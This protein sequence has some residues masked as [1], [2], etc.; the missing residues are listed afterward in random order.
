M[1]KK[2]Y[3][4]KSKIKTN[5]S[6]RQKSHTDFSEKRKQERLKAKE[7]MLNFISNHGNAY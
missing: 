2:L 5:E 7:S 4:S 3:T 6:N 1:W